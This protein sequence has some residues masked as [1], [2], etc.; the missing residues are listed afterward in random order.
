MARTSLAALT[1]LLVCLLNTSAAAAADTRLADAAQKR[2]IAAVRTLLSQKVDPNAPGR[3]GTPALLWLVRVDDVETAQLLVKAGAD[4][5]LANR[6]GLTP[7]ALAASNGSAAML[8]VLIDAGA[9]VNTP[10][11][12]GETPLML[13]AR[14]GKLDAVRVLMERG[15]TIE[16]KDAQF[17]QTALMVA[18]R[19]NHPQVVKLLVELGANVNA[20]TRVGI[21]PPVHPA[22]FR[23]RLRPWHR[24]RPRRLAGS[25]PA[26]S[27]PGRHVAAAVRGA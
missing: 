11:P 1:V 22:Q 7:L 18:V 17:E 21:T 15:A 2:D 6:Q 3:D 4:V 16:A 14:V 13:A 27:D 10:D 24:D 5:K 19:E 20:K 25:R 9:P 23:A 26:R 12:A 8:K